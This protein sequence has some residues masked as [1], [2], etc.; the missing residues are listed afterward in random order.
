[1]DGI[2]EDEATLTQE[3]LDHYDAQQQLKILIDMFYILKHV[4]L[5]QKM[6]Y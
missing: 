3:Q 6:N 4:Y 1:V 2:F 5:L